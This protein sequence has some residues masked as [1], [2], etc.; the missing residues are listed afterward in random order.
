VVEG[1]L[2]LRSNVNPKPDGSGEADFFYQLF[3]MQVIKDQPVTVTLSATG[4]EPVLEAGERETLGFV[5]SMLARTGRD[6]SARLVLQPFRTGVV[7]I[8]VRSSGLALGSW[9]LEVQPGVVQAP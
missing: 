5:G 4:F 9:R 3:R 6:R 2:T 8:R 7:F 1:S